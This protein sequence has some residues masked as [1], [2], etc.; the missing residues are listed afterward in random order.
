MATAWKQVKLFVADS[1]Q[2]VTIEKDPNTS[3]GLVLYL[4]EED[5]R[6]DDKPFT[7]YLDPDEVYEV[8]DEMK[9]M[10]EE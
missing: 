2:S 8:I 9:A 10:A 1:E 6:V 5:G 3:G 7:L 4:K